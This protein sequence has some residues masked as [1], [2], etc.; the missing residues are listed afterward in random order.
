MHL[1]VL[2]AIALGALSLGFSVGAAV[3]RLI[4]NPESQMNPKL[5]ALAN[6][7]VALTADVQTL[8]S[9]TGMHAANADLPAQLQADDAELDQVIAQATAMHDQVSNAIAAYQPAP[10]QG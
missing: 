10:A 6:L 3:E 8:I 5:T 2:I 1:V 4:F 9:I 7:V